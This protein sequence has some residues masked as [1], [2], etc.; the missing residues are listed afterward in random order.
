M[1]KSLVAVLVPLCLLVL[2][3][4]SAAHADSARPGYQSTGRLAPEELEELLAPIALYPDP[5]LAQLLPAATF[6]DQ[7]VYAARFLERYGSSARIDGE[8]WDVSVKAIAHYPEVLFMM[9]REYQ[10]TVTVGQAFL[11]QEPEVL[12]A[13]QR[14]RERAYAAGKLRST[15]EEQVIVQAG[16][17]RIVPADPLYLYVPRYDPR[18][19]YLE[20][21]PDDAPPITYGFGFTI[22]SWLNRDC[23]W[24]GRRV[25]YHG[26]RDRGWVK[27]SRP[28]VQLRNKAYV[29]DKAKEIRIDRSVAARDNSRYRQELR[30][31]SRSAARPAESP[32]VRVRRGPQLRPPAGGAQPGGNA[33]A[34]REAPRTHAPA[35]SSHS[36]ASPS[37]A[38]PSPS[39]SPATTAPAPTTAPAAPPAPAPATPAVPFPHAIAPD[40]RGR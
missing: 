23:D 21:R 32:A 8:E 28:H 6:T 33:P 10:W 9:E 15:R 38:S 30:T 13:I 35:T 29:G 11:N 24:G 17:I 34:G 7:I 31:S 18:T 16:Y 37:P 4:G 1:K 40:T 19:V 27:R 5:L 26:W 14:L 22:G 39:P 36:P 12:D 3:T 2:L 20:E 25:Y